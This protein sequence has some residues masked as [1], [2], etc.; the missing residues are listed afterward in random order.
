MHK[1]FLFTG[2]ILGAIAVA[3]GAFGAHSLKAIATP[4]TISVF[5]TAVRYQFYHCFALLITGIC[6]ERFAG[7]WIRYAGI[8]FITGIVLFSGSLYALAALQA[9]GKV[10]LGGIGILTPVGGLFF[11]AGWIALA[12]AFSSNRYKATSN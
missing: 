6:A 2:S 8:S 9:A 5:E 3:L 10:G 12:A 1:S 4:D 7:R 11:I